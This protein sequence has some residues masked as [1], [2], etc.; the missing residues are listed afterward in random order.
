MSL[1]DT[2]RMGTHRTVGRQKGRQIVSWYGCRT[3]PMRLVEM[4]PIGV[5]YRSIQA[6]SGAMRFVSNTPLGVRLYT[7]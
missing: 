6:R 3:V 5:A 7:R 2:R 1:S 4:G